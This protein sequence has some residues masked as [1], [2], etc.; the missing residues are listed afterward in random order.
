MSVQS[1]HCNMQEARESYDIPRRQAEKSLGLANRKLEDYDYGRIQTPIDIILAAAEEF[2]SPELLW[3]AYNQFPQ[4]WPHI[5]SPTRVEDSLLANAAKSAKEAQENVEAMNK[6]MVQV[7]GKVSAEDLSQMDRQLI[8]E[9]LVEGAEAVKAFQKFCL[10]LVKQ[11]DF[12]V[13]EINRIIEQNLSQN[14]AK[15]RAVR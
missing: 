4:Q 3:Q 12:G 15:I 5:P 14:Q 10:V 9:A 1:L 2:K 6:L 11:Y 13:K 8:I 7:Y